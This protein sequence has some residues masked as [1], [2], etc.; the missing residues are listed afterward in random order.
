MNGTSTEP[1]LSDLLGRLGDARAHLNALDEA[2]PEYEV[3]KM[4]AE[5][6]VETEEDRYETA[7]QVD[8]HNGALTQ[9]GSANVSNSPMFDSYQRPQSSSATLNVPKGFSPYAGSTMNAFGGHFA[10]DGVSAGQGRIATAPGWG[11]ESTNGDANVSDTAGFQL[12]G[13]HPSSGSNSTPDSGYLQRKRPRNS[14]DLSKN[15]SGQPNKSLRATPSPAM[16]GSTTPTS[17][18]SE[19]PD[20]PEEL[21]AALGGN[22]NEDLREMREEQ[23]RQDKLAK[24]KKEQMLRDEEYALALQNE[25]NAPSLPTG[26]PSAGPSSGFGAIQTATDHGD[27]YSQSIPLSSSPLVARHDSFADPFTSTVPSKQTD[28]TG[29][30]QASVKKKNAWPSSASPSEGSYGL[31]SN[32]PMKKETSYQPSPPRKHAFSDFI[33]LSSDDDS[34]FQTFDPIGRSNKG[35]T[36]TDPNVWGQSNPQN[37]PTELASANYN[38][39]SYSGPSGS[40][41]TE[42]VGPH[43]GNML[44]NVARNVYQTGYNL[45]DQL[46]LPPTGFGGSS[47]YNGSAYQYPENSSNVPII[48]LESD[49]DSPGEMAQALFDRHGYSADDPANRR[50]YEQYLD[51]VDYITHDPTRTAADIKN[52][53]ENIRPDEDLPPEDRE[54][55][56]EAMTYPLM[57]HQK[58]G[59]AWMRKMEESEHHRGGSKLHYCPR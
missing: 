9:M 59:L 41:N 22:P 25:W 55:T 7:R 16:T 4:A 17:Y 50:L 13:G 43:L 12:G 51:R 29:A 30:G 34:E 33:D 14:L 48:D 18:G 24:E 21:F 53:L 49:P 45:V 39:Y 54:G 27:R 47:V 42:G 11:F 40:S 46:G 28:Y 6:W 56:P 52:L 38:P 5:H 31:V 2:D 20:I 32:G 15:S 26:Q 58:L 57:E 44:S 37:H 1:S 23:K 36:K 10:S 3:N 19:F 35:L 8:R